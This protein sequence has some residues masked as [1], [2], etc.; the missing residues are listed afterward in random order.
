MHWSVYR[1]KTDLYVDIA[2]LLYLA[3]IIEVMLFIKHG[4]SYGVPH[5]VI[6]CHAALSEWSSDGFCLLIRLECIS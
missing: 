4:W 6:K 5:I 2:T 1:H 3:N